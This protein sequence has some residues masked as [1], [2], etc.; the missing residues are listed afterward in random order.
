ML[1]Q[2]RFARAMLR[3]THLMPSLAVTSFVAI[4]SI[5]LSTNLSTLWL[6]VLATLFQQFSVGLSNDWLDWQRDLAVGRS[7]KPALI[8]NITRAQT[9]NCAWVFVIAALVTSW[10]ISASAEAIMIVMLAAGWSYN[11]WLKSTVLSFV[12]YFVGFASLPFFANGDA[13]S[14]S[15]IPLFIPVV[16]GLLG[17]SAHFANAI[18]DL[19]DDA[20]NGING[21]PQRL[22]ALLSS[23]A[24]A[25]FALAAAIITMLN[26]SASIAAVTWICLIASIAFVVVSVCLASQQKP[27]RLA[28]NLLVVAAFCNLVPLCFE[29]WSIGK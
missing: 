14:A 26:C 25:L 21:L 18:P 12:P 6:I 29:M 1:Q 9:R 15:G 2:L 8:G 5:C 23:A 22:G 20:S 11:L 27:K 19:E 3:A 28:F 24:L 7:D 4:F 13:Q 10:Q 17:C 16:A